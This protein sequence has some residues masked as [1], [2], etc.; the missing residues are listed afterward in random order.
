MP[1]GGIRIVMVTGDYGLTAESV[2]RR[3]GIL[4]GG[5]PRILN[6][7]E[8]DGMGEPALEEALRAR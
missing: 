6:G 2:A 1:P 7:S 3:V 4:R 5:S 8:M